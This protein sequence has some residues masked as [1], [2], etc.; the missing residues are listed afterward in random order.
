MF[1]KYFEKI[2]KNLLKKSKPSAKTKAKKGKSTAKALVT[3][4]VN[5]LKDELNKIIPDR[6]M[7]DKLKMIDASGYTPEDVDL[8]AYKKLYRDMQ[9][10]MNGNIPCELVYGTYHIISKLNKENLNDVIRKVV[11]AR[12]VNRFIEREEPPIAIP[13][14]V[15]AYDTDY[16]LADLKAGIIDNYMSMSIDRYSEIDIIV[17][18]NKGII[19]KD[20]RDKR[21]Y[22]ALETGKDSFMWFFILMNEYLDIEKDNEFDPRNYIL[23]SEKYNEY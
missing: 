18:L 3:I 9:G 13:A 22:V 6:L 21:S 10:I 23:H 19:I 7:I 17:I 20:H 11:Q 1:S 5:Q 4:D 2:G 8:I 12:K 16:N 14:F 15:I